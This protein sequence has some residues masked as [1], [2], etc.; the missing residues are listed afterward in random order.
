MQT[1]TIQ[2]LFFIGLMALLSV[3]S[4]A[5]QTEV[6]QLLKNYKMVWNDEFDGPTFDASKWSYRSNGSTRNYAIVDGARTISQDNNG[7]LVISVTKEGDQYYV[8]QL[9][10]NGHYEK[11]YGYFECRARVN[12]Y[13]G[14][15]VAFWLQSPTMGNTP[16]NQPDIN[17][18][19][20]DVFEYHRKSPGV[21][22][23]TIHIN[24]YGDDHIQEGQQIAY[25][26][27]D[28]GYH[29]FGVLWTSSSYTFYVDGQKTYQTTFGLSKRT[30]YMIL[31]TELTGFGGDPSLG[32]YP[33][34][35]IYDYVR[36]YEPVQAPD[37]L[38]DLQDTTTTTATADTYTYDAA[39]GIN[40]NYGSSTS[41]VSKFGGG[42]ALETLPSAIGY[43]RRTYL[44]FPSATL[45]SLNNIQQVLL[46]LCY[47]NKDVMNQSKGVKVSL[48]RLS[49]WKENTLTWNSQLT[50]AGALDSLD[51]VLDDGTLKPASIPNPISDDFI[52]TDAH[53]LYLDITDTIQKMIQNGNLPDTLSLVLQGYAIGS[54]TQQYNSGYTYFSKE[55]KNT[56]GQTVD[57]LSPSLVAYSLKDI[58]T[59]VEA[60]ALTARLSGS[61]VQ[62]Q[63]KT[64]KE[65]NSDYF[66][67]ERSQDGSSFTRL[68]TM[69]AAGNSSQPLTYTYLDKN[70]LPGD[71]YYR[72]LTMDKTGAVSSISNTV[73]LQT[74]ASDTTL[75]MML[76]P[77]P[78][79]GGG[80]LTLQVASRTAATGHI[81]LTDLRGR[82]LTAFDR[83]IKVGRQSIPLSTDGLSSGIYFISLQIKGIKKTC[84]LIIK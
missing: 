79:S 61:L 17:G 10:T 49:S 48:S 83:Q 12:K 43:N 81:V 44:K 46:R 63:W 5:Q 77:N 22:W 16:Y 2:R 9:T 32:Q 72:Y 20:I 21:V 45:R 14:P 47:Y 42:T 55:F 8:G 51:T 19:E 73:H 41:L 70:P 69:A 64:Y 7:H 67:I 26:A 75:Q 38:K 68:T 25:P 59:P 18:A 82:R 29:T 3:K 80:R 13:I 65:I 50:D 84:K 56:A 30:E 27:V 23:Q 28:T 74:T 62:L 53:Y 52:Q 35:V 11:K 36:V 76:Y 78:A 58:T 54:G 34:S 40:S 37:S 6:D 57:S 66:I 71:N 15:H 4:T 31:S 60:S 24:G 39:A 1:M 33:D